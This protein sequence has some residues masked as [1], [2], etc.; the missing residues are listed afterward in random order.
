MTLKELEEKARALTSEDRAK[1]AEGKRPGT[2]VL[3]V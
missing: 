2:A 3:T 1:L